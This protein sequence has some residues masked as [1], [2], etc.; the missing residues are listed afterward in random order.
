MLEEYEH[1]TQRLRVQFRCRCGVPTS[2]R[3][4]ML[5]VYRLPYCEECSKGK[6]VERCEK[7]CMEKYGV[8]NAAESEEI[9]QKIQTSWHTKFGDHPKR[10]KE[11]QEK[12][13]QTCLEKYGGHPN[14]N[15]DVQVKSEFKG[16]HYKDYIFPSGKVVKVQGYE[17]LALDKLLK[18]G[19]CEMNIIV[20]KANI[21]VIEYYLDN[22]RHVYYPDIFIESEHKLIEVKSQ[23]SMKFPTHIQEKALASV[24]EGYAYEI[25]IYNGNKS[26]LKRI[27]YM[28]DGSIQEFP[29]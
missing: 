14:Q 13:K 22:K 8:K 23:W 2:K 18:D 11:V 7:T 1:F 19:I 3:F 17:H 28:F 9:K 25:W 16:Y 27:A 6:I 12:W 26:F 24:A 10:I 20:G 15:R 4:E 21:P 5:K 29:A